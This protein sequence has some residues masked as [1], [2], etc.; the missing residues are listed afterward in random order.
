MFRR[1]LLG[2]TFDRVHEGHAWLINQALEHCTHLEIWITSDDVA[3][4]KDK[5]CWD[6]N[7]RRSEIEMIIESN[8]RSRVSFGVLHDSFGPAIEHPNADAII[9]TNETLPGCEEINR[10]RMEN[11][12]KPLEIIVM[13]HARG[14]DGELI[15]SSRIRNGTIYQSGELFVHE[16]DFKGTRNLTPEVESMLKTPFG[17]LH[18]GPESDHAIALT[19]ALES[20]QSDTN[21]VAVGDVTV[22]GLL[23]LSCTPDIALIDGMTKRDNWPNAKLIDRSKFDI[24]ST[25]WNPAGKLTPQLFETCKNAV[26]SLNHRLKS[27]IVVDGEEDLSPIMLHLLLPVD[28]V[29]I[30]G[31]PGRGVVTRVTDLETKKNCRLILESM[32]IDNS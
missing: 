25:A 28:S 19:K 2:G 11:Q 6:W 31:Q 10:I 3:K 14:S 8:S 15:S 13:D 1:G 32:A 24:V 29:I 21:I 9:C 16:S 22:F 20:I 4:T 12:M 23:K 30:Y 27:L 26:N 5:R 17:I 18:E 7:R